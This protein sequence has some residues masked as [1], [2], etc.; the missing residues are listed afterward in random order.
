MLVCLK[1]LEHSEIV[2]LFQC[3]RCTPL[4]APLTETFTHLEFEGY[5]KMEI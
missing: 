1:A 4:S 2:R 3:N 5:S